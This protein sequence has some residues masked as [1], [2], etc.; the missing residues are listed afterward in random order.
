MDALLS[1]LLLSLLSS[2]SSNVSISVYCNGGQRIPCC[3]FGDGE[4]MFTQMRSS[5]LTTKFPNK[6]EM[7]ST[8]ANIYYLLVC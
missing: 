5:Y 3:G 7:H 2:T 8:A 6:S 4:S 1:L